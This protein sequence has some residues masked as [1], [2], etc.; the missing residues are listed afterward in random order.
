MSRAVYHAGPELHFALAVDK[1][2]HFTSP[3]RRYPDTLTHQVLTEYLA[4]GKVLRWEK[5]AMGLAWSDGGTAPADKP[6]RD[7]KAIP[8]FERWEFSLPHIAAFCTERS[9]RSD[10]G[11]LAAD[12]IKVLR[13]LLPRVGE[14]MNGTVISIAGNAVVVQLDENMA[15]GY[16]EFSE[17]SD[18]WAEVHKFWV[19]YETGSGVRKIMLGDRMEVEIAGIDLGS[20][21]MRLTPLGQFAMERTWSRTRER[22]DRRKRKSRGNKSSRGRKRRR[23]K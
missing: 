4:L 11:E 2:V 20:R 18:S 19:H 13:T 17:L 12:Q 6:K 10:K 5:Q 9:I 1:Y 22:N 7:G 3:I 16:L 21:S 14:A 8:D 23:R 15:E